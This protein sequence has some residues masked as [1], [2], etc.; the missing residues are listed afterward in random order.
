[1][2]GWGGS[3]VVRGRCG[4]PV[5]GGA[6]MPSASSSGAG[7]VPAAPPVGSEPGQRAGFAGGGHGGSGPVV[8]GGA[9]VAT[10][11]LPAPQAA[12]P[13]TSGAAVPTSAPQ[14]WGVG[15]VVPVLAAHPQVGVSGVALAMA[16]AAAAAGLSVLLVD[17]ADPRRSGLAGIASHEGPTV[18]VAGGSWSVRVSLRAPAGG[19]PVQV[20]RSVAPAAPWTP[21]DMPAPGAWLMAA[22][23]WWDLAV[24]D[25]GWDAWHLLSGPQSL[26]PMRWLSGDRQPITPVLVVRATV[27]SLAAA[28]GVLSRYLAAYA[29]GWLAGVGQVAVVGASS[30][31]P[32]VLGGAGRLA[33]LAAGREVFVPWVRSAAVAGWSASPLPVELLDAGRRLLAGV[34]GRV[35]AAVGPIPQPRRPSRRRWRHGPYARYG[36]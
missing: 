27:P 21:V 11:G 6:P 9:R 2:V 18:P 30:W 13:P 5:H 29:A 15:A 3:R 25:L 28:E 12:V 17:G 35:A 8:S 23:G 33:R 10:T 19:R 24:V 26:G 1:M 31:P 14:E 32:R 16:D 4:V 36:P 20:R 34:G 7:S 22:P